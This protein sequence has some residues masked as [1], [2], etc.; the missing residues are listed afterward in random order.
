MAKAIPS[1]DVLRQLLRYEP[2]TGK[3]FWLERGVEWFSDGKFSKE[4]ACKI[5][6]SKFAG[7][8]AFTAMCKGYHRGCVL[9]VHTEAHRVIWAMQT[10]E[11]PDSVDHQNGV[12]SDNRWANLRNVSHKE[13]MRNTKRPSHNKSGV[14]GVSYCNYYQKWVAHIQISKT[15]KKVRY[16][17]TKEEAVA[18]RR[19]LERQYGFHQN[20]G[21]A[22]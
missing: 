1:P 17:A 21:R 13:N 2:E 12:G 18:E 16:R 7:K 14:M 11:W 9:S 19:A 5:W 8:Q 10:G 20:H 4:H 15:S 22:A 6:N 3:L